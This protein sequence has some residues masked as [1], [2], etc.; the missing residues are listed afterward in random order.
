[1]RNE[2][3]LA[4]VVTAAF[5]FWYL[6]RRRR[7]RRQPGAGA[8]S[9]HSSMGRWR[10]F[11]KP[12]GIRDRRGDDPAHAVAD[13]DAHAAQGVESRGHVV[14]ADEIG[15]ALAGLSTAACLVSLMLDRD[16][17]PEPTL[18]DLTFFVLAVTVFRIIRTIWVLERVIDIVTRRPTA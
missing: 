5:V 13:E 1:M 7:C 6:L 9:R 8:E 16:G 18:L 3:L 2:V 10:R 17:A 15:D 11:G 14:G 12:A 4:L